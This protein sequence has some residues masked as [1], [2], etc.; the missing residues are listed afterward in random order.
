MYYSGLDEDCGSS[1]AGESDALSDDG[2]GVAKLLEQVD[3]LNELDGFILVSLADPTNFIWSPH[4]SR[5]RRL[6]N[7]VEFYNS[8]VA[9][10]NLDS[11]EEEIEKNETEMSDTNNPLE[12]VK[13]ESNYSMNRS[14]FAN[15]SSTFNI[16]TEN[17]IVPAAFIVGYPA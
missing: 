9:N 5:D 10:K 16:T 15:T 7:L 12:E 8:L 4:D 1:L 2:R 3:K 14:Y 6:I 13:D 11:M 17:N